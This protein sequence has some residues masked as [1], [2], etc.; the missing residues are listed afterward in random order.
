MQVNL[1]G[2]DD[3]SFQWLGFTRD[4]D[5]PYKPGDKFTVSVS[6]YIPDGVNNIGIP[7]PILDEK[8]VTLGE[9][10]AIVTLFLPLSLSRAS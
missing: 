6:K 7:Q 9:T 2:A 5:S 4:S 1:T 8:T 3:G 10:G